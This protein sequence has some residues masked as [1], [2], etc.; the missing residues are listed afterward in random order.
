MYNLTYEQLLDENDI[1]VLKLKTIYQ[2]PEVSRYISISDNYFCYVTSSADV[3]FYKLYNGDNQI[4]A[5]QLEKQG[6]LLYMSILIFPQFQGKGF[7]TEV[8]NDIKKDILK[9]DYKKIEVSVDEENIASLRVFTKAGFTKVSKC[10]V[11][12]NFVYQRKN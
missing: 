3:Y 2:L 11:L 1:D 4:G 6:D 8:I 7:A 10:G 5:I 9:L 12:I